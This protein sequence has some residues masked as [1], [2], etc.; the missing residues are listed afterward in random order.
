MSTDLSVESLVRTHVE[1]VLRHNANG[2]VGLAAQYLKIG[3]TTLYRW[4]HGWGYT[5][6][7]L[8]ASVRSPYLVKDIWSGKTQ[9]SQKQN[10]ES[11]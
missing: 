6:Q 8:S 5:R 2:D 3:K 11:D 7:S 1:R 4:L 10:P 9:T